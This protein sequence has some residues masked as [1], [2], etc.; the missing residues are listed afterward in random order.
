MTVL[1]RAALF[2]FFRW[3]IS[4]G[5]G[6]WS[7]ARSKA[8]EFFGQLLVQSMTPA[9]IGFF[10]YWAVFSWVRHPIRAVPYAALILLAVPGVWALYVFIV[11]PEMAEVVLWQ[12]WQWDVM[13][14]FCAA[15]LVEGVEMLSRRLP[16]P[17]R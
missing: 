7:L 14:G 4:V 1:L 5:V 3:T 17:A 16:A 6:A 15:C 10:L 12:N 2:A 8:P 11:Y 9:V 13:S